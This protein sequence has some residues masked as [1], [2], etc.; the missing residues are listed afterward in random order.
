M[1]EDAIAALLSALPVRPLSLPQREL[2]IKLREWKWPPLGDYNGFCHQQRVLNWQV[3]LWLRQAGALRIPERCDLCRHVSQLGLHSENYADIERHL[4]LCQECHFAV[5]R[6]FRSPDA[7]RARC[8]GDADEPA[9]LLA[10]PPIKT[11]VAS[12]LRKRGRA[13][14]INQLPP[15]CNALVD[16]LR[17]KGRLE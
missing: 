5:H 10:L 3:S 8:P 4:A 12:W 14:L 1:S 2:P 13:E 11:D 17:R 9:W 7:L 15:W 16:H 6:R